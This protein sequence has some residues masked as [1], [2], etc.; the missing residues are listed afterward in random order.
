MTESQAWLNPAYTPECR[1]K[2]LLAAI[3]TKDD[4]VA[5]AASGD[6]SAYGITR[7]NSKDGPAGVS[8]GSGKQ[9][10]FP[11]PLGLA[12]SFDT[13]LANA[14]GAAVG[15]EFHSS[16]YGTSLGPTMDIERTWHFARAAESYGEDPY[17]AGQIARPVVD[18]IQSKHVITSLKHF[19]VYNQDAG[20]TGED[21]G[22]G[23]PKYAFTSYNVKVSNRAL[24]EIYFPPFKAAVVNGGAGNVMTS[25][26]MINGKFAAE[27]QYVLG[28][29]KNQWGF[30]GAVRPDYPS[31][32]HTIP[33]IVAGMDTVS[34]WDTKFDDPTSVA[35]VTDEFKKA[36]A[37]GIVT[38]DR[39]NDLIKRALVPMWRVGLDQ[40]P[41]TSTGPDVAAHKAVAVQVATD[42]AVLL[43]NNGVLPLSPS[44]KIAVIGRQ[45][46]AETNI[47]TLQ[48]KVNVCEYGSAFVWP[49]HL[50]TA[51]SAIKSKAANATYAPGNVGVGEL[52]LLKVDATGHTADGST[53][54]TEKG[55][56]TAG[57]VAN[58]YGTP[59]LTGSP[60][61]TQVETAINMEEDLRFSTP[62]APGTL[63]ANH[64]WSVDWK[65]FFTPKTT[66][67]YRFSL[68][69]GGIAQLY[70]NSKLVAGKRADFG[71]V[72]S[73]A[74]TL[75]A[76]T[77][78][79]IEV[80]YSARQGLETGIM[81]TTIPDIGTILGTFCHVGYAAAD[82]AIADAAAAAKAAD[83]AVVF[84]SDRTGEGG[85]REYLGLRG[86]QN[87]L[88]AAVAAAN[89]KT[90]VVLT[91][92]SP[93][94]M[95]WLKDVAGVLEMWYPGDYFGDAAAA[96]LFG[97]VNPS[98]KLPMTF[99]ADET[100]G[101]AT[102]RAQYPGLNVDGTTQVFGQLGDVNYDEG[103]LVGYR[104]Y[105]AKKQKPLFEFGYGLS[106]T[107]F[108]YADI[109]AT[110]DTAT[111]GITVTAKI[112]NS[113]SKDGAE[114]A[115]LYLGFPASAGEP[116]K[117]LKGFKKVALKAGASTTVKF[118]VAAD[119][120]AIFDESKDGWEP[121]CGDY[122][123]YVGSSS[124][125][126]RGQAT[127]AVD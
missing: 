15:E 114:V 74:V 77:T 63:P 59:D 44:A 97:D 119:E 85:D 37:D 22:G 105:D 24:H 78:V 104:W 98:G 11:A 23:N 26:P 56:T 80:K 111:G 31:Y 122:T 48:A 41:P 76:A 32:W 28:A 36:V 106:Y 34:A 55:G 118:T 20:R 9:T 25:F 89:P 17:L 69:V 94:A 82:T 73:C 52:D 87:N 62:F 40:N 68:G 67:I 117:V 109:S 116:P 103:I 38:E 66:G 60:V 45:A 3:P 64:Q 95:P 4:K 14:Y 112:T 47:G 49:T 120:L 75:T 113:G 16:G 57:F 127:V 6:F 2:A 12:A 43:K 108:D 13:T 18:G 88:I 53:L 115:Q 50:T 96:L 29:L 93:I 19:V 110:R 107:T 71:N 99:P 92:G 72:D 101:P 79:P 123:A 83:V 126:I 8:N 121:V 21:N 70:V 102:T 7:Y 35:K 61:K 91:N 84:V 51:E 124:Q 46:G 54:M 100:Q 27:N 65:G 81:V 125:D 1:A 86:D 39:V 5:L 30:D 10:A 42:G 90:V 33:A 58:Y